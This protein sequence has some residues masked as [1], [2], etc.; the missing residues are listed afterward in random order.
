MAKFP[1]DPLRE[2]VWRE[3]FAAWSKSG[4]SIRRFC[5]QQAIPETSFH[6]WLRKLR[7]RE[8]GVAVT[9]KPSFVPVTVIPSRPMIATSIEV[10]CPSGHVALV[11]IHDAATIRQLFEALTA[12]TKETSPC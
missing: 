7:S 3:R 10:R 2:Q 12:S 4:L 5:R 11:P 9:S 8:P 6:F 1:R